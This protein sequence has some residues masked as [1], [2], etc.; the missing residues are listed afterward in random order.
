MPDPLAFRYDVT[1]EYEKRFWEMKNERCS[2]VANLWDADGE[3]SV[4]QLFPHK[5]PKNLGRGELL[6]LVDI[7]SRYFLEQLSHSQAFHQNSCF[8]FPRQ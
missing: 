3:D 5:Q 6:A 1:G 8:S 4:A 7:L 2:R